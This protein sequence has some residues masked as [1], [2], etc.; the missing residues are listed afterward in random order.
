MSIRV[1][2]LSIFG[3]LSKLFK[4]S[5][6]S[7]SPQNFKE[8]FQRFQNLLV[9]NDRALENMAQL[10]ESLNQKEPFAFG[11]GRRLIIA[12]L[13]NCRQIIG[14]LSSI[15]PGRFQDLLIQY[16]NIY[17]KENLLLSITDIDSE[18]T[19]EHI[20]SKIENIPYSIDFRDI[21]MG[22][23]SRVG[24]KMARL[25][26]MKNVLN[27]P[28]PDGICL[29]SRCFE[30]FFT[31]N[32]LRRKIDDLAG[33]LNINNSIEI[34]TASRAIQAML[35]SAPIPSHIEEEILNAYD[36]L[37]K[38][39]GKECSVA[40]RSSA[41]GED[42]PA[43]SFAGLHYTALN[44]SRAN[45]VDA[46]W[47]VLISKYLP[48]SMVYRF[49]TGLR[50]SDMPMNIC[51]MVMLDP[52]VS[53]TLF[54]VDPQKKKPGM[55]IQTVKGVGSLVVEGKVSPQ[56]YI[57][58]RNSDAKI[59]E[60][61][62]GSQ[63]HL[64]IPRKGDGLKQ[65]ELDPDQI[66]EKFLTQKQIEFLVNYGLSIEAHFGSP[67]DIEWAITRDDRIFVLQTRPLQVVDLEKAQKNKNY[68]SD[69][70]KS[71]N[72]VLIEGG[73]CASSGSGSGPV[74]IAGQ[75]RFLVNFPDG[76]VLI[77]KKSTPT[78]A[79]VLH[80]AAAVVTEIGSTTGHLSIIARE[81]GVPTILNL[82]NAT[83]ILKNDQYI[84][85]DADNG[86]IFSGRVKELSLKNMIKTE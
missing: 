82:K 34:Q 70:I 77:A 15:C 49:V 51:C 18:K 84:T 6:K 63:N 26:E 47:E 75:E 53:G 81:L 9:A 79:Q 67:Q 31:I 7:R 32:N 43:H 35:V 11:R 50:D 83:S 17:E 19:D 38:R 13:E 5:L 73:D 62:Q 54:T 37:C 24:G 78:F 71:R 52:K 56:E 48:E 12:I 20:S 4:F 10:S 44:V 60:F 28:V 76:G 30:E 29:T 39:V 68:S 64:L 16:E 23:I 55:I 80:K 65:V 42:D 14:F 36:R 8:K 86:L 85:V 22:L 46:C 33:N 40:V 69:D 72:P 2:M 74:F 61:S 27:N 57:I 41:V 59:I 58:N 25:G 21:D 45:L 3:K 1:K 66:H